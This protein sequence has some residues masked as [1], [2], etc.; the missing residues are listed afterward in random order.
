LAVVTEELVRLRITTEA[1]AVLVV[2]ALL[3][4]LM[5]RVGQEHQAKEMPE[6]TQQ[7]LAGVEAVALAP[8]VKQVMS[9]GVNLAVTAE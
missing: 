7:T 8:L 4:V 5:E 3:R 1:L 9:G 6:E 2:V